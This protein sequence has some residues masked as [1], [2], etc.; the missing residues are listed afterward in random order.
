MLQ[1]ETNINSSLTFVSSGDF[2]GCGAGAREPGG[3]S[4]LE[5]PQQDL[6]G[7][8]QRGPLSPGTSAGT[9]TLSWGPRH[10]HLLTLPLQ[11]QLSRLF[12]FRIP[13]FCTKDPS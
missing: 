7:D 13:C 10:S 8:T 5:L 6:P 11:E 4:A 3:G 9:V 2:Y 12:L 1:V